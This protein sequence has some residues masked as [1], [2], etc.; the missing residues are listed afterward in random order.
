MLYRNSYARFVSLR[1]H[2]AGEDLH[3]DIY[4]EYLFPSPDDDA[5]LHSMVQF[6][7]ERG[8]ERATPFVL[9]AGRSAVE[10]PLNSMLKLTKTSSLGLCSLTFER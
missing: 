2:L 6:E 1:I 7:K 4:P 9:A 10:V 3:A 8:I 5:F